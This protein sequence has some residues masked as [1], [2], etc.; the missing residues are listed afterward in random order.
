MNVLVAGGLGQLGTE[1]S[2]MLVDN[3]KWVFAGSNDFDIT[4]YES[5]LN[6]IALYKPDVIVN[7]A[8]YTAVDK[9]E[10]EPELAQEIN[11]QGA[12]LLA[13]ACAENNIRLIHISTDF[14]FGRS[15]GRL[16]APDT[17]C[18]PTSVYGSSK[19][20]GEALVRK[21]LPS[22]VIARTSWLYSSHSP[23]FVRT[24]I[25]LMNEREQLGIVSDQIGSP[26]A[27]STL[28]NWIVHVIMSTDCTGTFHV[29][30]AG[31]ASWYDF[32]VAI[33][34]L[35][36]DKN[37][38]R[39]GCSIKPI[40]TENYPTPAKRPFFSAFD[41]SQSFNQEGLPASQHWR[42]VLSQTLDKMEPL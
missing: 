18:E 6:G 31:V 5:I 36:C 26:T 7:A 4:D 11:A 10:S 39:T 9:A 24:M 1:L 21:F 14:V 15:D 35:G 8:A 37:L 25:R 3:S 20:D 40:L 23:C 33:Y 42:S 22:A 17:P 30:D 29:S 19:A 34:E 12:C 16:L 2:Q 28:A 13:K 27:C 41:I 32:A 38:I